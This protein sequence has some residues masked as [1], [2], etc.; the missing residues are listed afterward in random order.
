MDDIFYNHAHYSEIFSQVNIYKIAGAYY[1]II[2]IVRR[3]IF[4]ISIVAIDD[5]PVIQCLVAIFLNFTYIFYV[6]YWEPFKTKYQN[7]M[8]IFNETINM[9]ITY[10]FL[11]FTDFVS[12]MD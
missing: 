1:Q 7:K 12:E 10:N 3:L 9:I 5:K 6:A 8:E 11:I 2:F 4:G